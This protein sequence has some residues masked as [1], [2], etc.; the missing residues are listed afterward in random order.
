MGKINFKQ[1]LDSNVY[2]LFT[3]LK[4]SCILWANRMRRFVWFGNVCKIFSS[5]VFFLQL[6]EFYAKLW[7]LVWVWVYVCVGPAIPLLTL[8]TAH[9]CKLAKSLYGWSCRATKIIYFQFW[10]ANYIIEAV[11]SWNNL[12]FINVI[13][14]IFFYITEIFF[15]PSS[16][17]IVV[18]YSL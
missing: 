16:F 8:G 3:F 4:K 6:E 14:R 12:F 17:L 2:V 7:S 9:G 10:H 5:V 15:C 13:E 18:F 1:Y 11:V